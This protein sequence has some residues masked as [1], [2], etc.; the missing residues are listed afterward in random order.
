MPS[1]DTSSSQTN[2]VTLNVGAIVAS[3]V[4]GALIT[5]IIGLI[6]FF[7]WKRRMYKNKKSSEVSS[8]VPA[9]QPIAVS[10]LYN[11]PIS[12][13]NSSIS[14]CATMEYHLYEELP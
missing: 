3:I 10:A 12:Q 11:F 13:Q 6:I 9:A 14:S 4:A 8:S 5:I 1:G 2:I 7:I